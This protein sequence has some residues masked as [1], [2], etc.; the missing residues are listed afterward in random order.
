[1]SKKCDLRKI[2]DRPQPGRTKVMRKPK[3]ASGAESEEASELW[4]SD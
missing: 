1:M 2:T 4:E 3:K